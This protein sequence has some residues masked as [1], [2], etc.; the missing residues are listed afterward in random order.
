[1]VKTAQAFRPHVLDMFEPQDHPDDIPYP[2]AAPTAPYDNAG[3]TLALQMG[4]QFDR[5]LD[6]FTGPFEPIAGVRAPRPAGRVEAARSPGQGSARRADGWYLSHRVN[7]AVSAINQLLERDAAVYWLEQVVEGQ[8]A[9]TFYIRNTGA[10]VAARVDRLARELGLVFQAA[11]RRPAGEHTRLRSARTALWDRYG[12]SMESGWTR[13]LLEQ[14]RFSFDVA[15]PRELEADELA[16]RYDVVVLVNGSVPPAATLRAPAGASREPDTTGIPAEYRSQLGSIRA[17]TVA[18]LRR[19]L[20][21]GG[22]VVAIGSGT[23]LA[24]A[25]G[26]PVG[27]HLVDAQD[28]PLPRNRYY[29]PGS[30]LQAAVDTTQALAHGLPARADVFFDNSP[31]FRLLPGAEAQDIRVLAH[32]DSPAPLRSGWAWGQE[33]LEGGIAAAVAPVGRGQLVLLGPEVAFRAQPHGT[34]KLLFNPLLR[35]AA[36]SEPIR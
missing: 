18:A 4:V 11:S 28:Q 19:F 25:L 6:G 27:S 34:F 35:A 14:F 20:E 12:G 23:N 26:V 7:D 36:R 24:A 2:G 1:V 8:A 3:W 5:V 32:F 21:R 31:V 16:E 22:T 15:Y 30:V 10:V 9:G 17:E 13:W 29:V 33:H